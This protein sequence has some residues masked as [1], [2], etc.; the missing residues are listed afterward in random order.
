VILGNVR[1]G[2]IVVNL[3]MAPSYDFRLAV[4]NVDFALPLP[5]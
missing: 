4:V 2:G 1:T 3:K 5:H